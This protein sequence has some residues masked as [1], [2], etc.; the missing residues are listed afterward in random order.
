MWKRRATRTRFK[1][2]AIPNPIFEKVLVG[3]GHIHCSY[4]NIRVQFIY[5]ITHDTR[6][7]VR[8]II[9]IL[10]SQLG[11]VILA[12]RALLRGTPAAHS[13]REFLGK[14]SRVSYTHIYTVR[15]S[16]ISDRPSVPV[17]RGVK[18]MASETRN[19]HIILMRTI[20]KGR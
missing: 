9:I 3:R 20:F 2:V 14:L 16:E 10:W 8:S 6:V 4:W 7:R 12:R 19:L 5:I 13:V 11:G 1:N 15:K 18:T 17:A